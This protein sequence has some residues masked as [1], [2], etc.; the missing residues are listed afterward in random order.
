MLSCR[1]YIIANN[2]FFCADQLQDPVTT[3]YKIIFSTFEKKSMSNVDPFIVAKYLWKV[4]MIPFTLSQIILKKYCDNETFEINEKHFVD[5]MK[6][7]NNTNILAIPINVDLFIKYDVDKNNFI[8][9]E[10]L[11]SKFF[12]ENTSTDTRTKIK[13]VMKK[14]KITPFFELN[15][16]DFH[17]VMNGVMNY[18]T[19][20]QV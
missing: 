2:M 4:Y 7:L 17:K 13:K 1:S 15:F 20:K 12:E 3:N 6:E 10:D 19:S 9:R 16:L 11:L 14:L 8:T 5:L 18:F